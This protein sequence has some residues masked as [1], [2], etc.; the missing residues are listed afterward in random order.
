[1]IARCDTGSGVSGSS[2]VIVEPTTVSRSRSTSATTPSP[3]CSILA[4]A[5][6]TGSVVMII[7]AG[8]LGSVDR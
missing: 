5:I 2:A 8:T 1:V 6:R 4:P 3:A 7:A